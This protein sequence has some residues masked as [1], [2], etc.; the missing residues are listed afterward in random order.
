MAQDYTKKPHF[1]PP[2]KA[3]ARILA[4]AAGDTGRVL[5][6]RVA[7]RDLN[8]NLAGGAGKNRG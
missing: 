4:A 5:N 8:H 6:R 1:A 2:K 3:N 7:L